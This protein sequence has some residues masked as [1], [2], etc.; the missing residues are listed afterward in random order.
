MP[1]CKINC[2]KQVIRSSQTRKSWANT[3]CIICVKLNNV[4]F[5]ILYRY[6]LPKFLP[7]PLPD[8]LGLMVKDLLPQTAPQDEITHVLLATNFIPSHQ[9]YSIIVPS[10]HLHTTGTYNVFSGLYWDLTLNQLELLNRRTNYLHF[11]F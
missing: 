1:P 7:W 4:R 10:D 3:I 6:S 2:V 9:F 8:S 5:T 11:F